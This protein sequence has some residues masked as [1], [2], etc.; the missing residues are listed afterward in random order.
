MHHV[1]KAVQ[2]FRRREPSPWTENPARWKIDDLQLPD[3]VA[4][5]VQN[6]PAM[7]LLAWLSYLSP[8][9]AT[10]FSHA[11]EILAPFIISCADERREGLA[12][13]LAVAWG[14]G[15]WDEST[16]GVS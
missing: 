16:F 11:L 7:L 13:E 4:E 2:E 14:C 15:A 12:V 9:E 10:D 3:T 1:V 5:L 6:E 8:Q